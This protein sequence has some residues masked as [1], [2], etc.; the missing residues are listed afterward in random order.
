MYVALRHPA[1]NLCLHRAYTS[2]HMKMLLGREKIVEKNI[3]CKLQI[4]P[5]F[6]T[7]QWRQK[8]TPLLLPLQMHT[9]DLC[10]YSMYVCT[11]DLV[12]TVLLSLMLPNHKVRQLSFQT[13]PGRWSPSQYNFYVT[14]S[15]SLYNTLRL[16]TFTNL[17]SC[18]FKYHLSIS[19]FLP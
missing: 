11:S 2:A 13:V 10:M 14:G 17:Y 18:D 19:T 15:I 4:Q 3:L 6:G 1:E 8:E 16:F 5:C 9:S 7:A 12:Y